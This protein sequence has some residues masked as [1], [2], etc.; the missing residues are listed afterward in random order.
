MWLLDLN[1]KFECDW[2]IELVNNKVSSN[3]LS[4]NNLVSELVEN[5]S[6]LN[7]TQ[8][9]KLQFLWLSAK[10]ALLILKQSFE[11]K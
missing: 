1:Y 7:Q 4:H 2:L 11:Q 3:K 9:T 8:S 5:K 6:F 10:T